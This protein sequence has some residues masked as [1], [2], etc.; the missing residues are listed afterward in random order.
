MRF[1]SVLKLDNWPLAS[2]VSKIKVYKG[3]SGQTYKTPPELDSA[4]KSL[5]STN[6]PEKNPR[7][8]EVPEGKCSVVSETGY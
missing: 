2:G 3:I 7:P 6:S 4:L 8:A 1:D 5:S